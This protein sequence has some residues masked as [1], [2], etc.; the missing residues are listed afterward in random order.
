MTRAVIVCF[1]LLTTI[2]AARETLRDEI[3]QEF[4][5]STFVESSGQNKSVEEKFM[6]TV[7]VEEGLDFAPG[8]VSQKCLLCM[9]KLESGGCK[10]IGCRMDVGSLSCGYFQIKQPYWIDCGK[11]GKDWKSCSNDINCSSKCVQQYMK[12]Y[13]THYRCPLN[14]EGFAREHNGGPNGCH[15]SRTL[16][17]WELLQKIPGCKGVKYS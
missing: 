7:S 11:P 16:K 5:R 4:F 1:I 12:R 13:A 2:C 8:M 17:Y 3:V 9:C 10:P 6:E 14:C 15:N